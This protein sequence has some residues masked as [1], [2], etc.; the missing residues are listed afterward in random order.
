LQAFTQDK[1]EDLREF[2]AYQQGN[3]TIVLRNKLTLS[4]FDFPLS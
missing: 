2:D 3:F 4:I 1:A